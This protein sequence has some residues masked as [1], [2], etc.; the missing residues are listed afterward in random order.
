MTSGHEIR[1]A[2]QT[3]G[4]Q[5][6][7]VSI[8]PYD[9]PIDDLAPLAHGVVFG[10]PLFV[11]LRERGADYQRVET[12]VLDALRRAFGKEPAVIRHQAVFFM[13]HKT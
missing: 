2:L 1:S 7:D 12:V 3:A 6:I 10:S 4:F 11:Q 9:H 13:A 8:V 5:R